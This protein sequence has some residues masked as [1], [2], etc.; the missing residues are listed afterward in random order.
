MEYLLGHIEFVLWSPGATTAES[1]G[2]SAHALRREVTA[3]RSPHTTTREES[4]L[5]QTRESP[6]VAIKTQH[7]H[8]FSSVAQSCPTLCDPV[9]CSTPGFPVYHQLLEPTQT[10]VHYVGDAIQPSHP[11]SSPSPPAFNLPSIRIFSSESALR[12]FLSWGFFFF[13]STLLY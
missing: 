7:I 9:D 12:I 5:P 2:H 4:P 1:R 6:R 3:M 8:Q 10:H 11:L 13:L